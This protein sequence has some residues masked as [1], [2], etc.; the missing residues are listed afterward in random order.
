MPVIS[1]TIDSND[2]ILKMDFIISKS[3][4]LDTVNLYKEYLNEYP[5]LKQLLLF[6]KQSFFLAKLN[7]PYDVN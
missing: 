2:R 3:K 4:E 5:V 1:I 7:K 6:L